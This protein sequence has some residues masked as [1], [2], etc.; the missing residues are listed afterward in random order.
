M[1]KR[2]KIILFIITFMMLLSSYGFA[3]GSTNYILN[4]D[5]VTKVPIPIS[6]SVTKVINYLGNDVSFDSPSDLFIDA[7]DNIYVADTGNNRI[8]KLNPDGSF[9]KIYDNG[10]TLNQPSGIFV[11]DTGDLYIAD[12]GNQQIVHLSEN[13][14]FVEKFVKPTSD[15][16]SATMDFSV[17][18]LAV[19]NQGYIYVI[20]DQQFMTIDAKD[21]FK[22]FIG[23]NQIGFDLTRLLIRMFATADQKKKLAQVQ[24]PVYTNF[25]IANDGMIYAVAPTTSGQ[26]KVINPI[27]QNIYP[28]KFYGEYFTT[29]SRFDKYPNFVDI[30]VDNDGII[31]ALE[32]KTKQLYQYDQEGNLLSVF[33]GD[34]TIQGKFMEP[35]SL[36]INSKGELFVL[37]AGA[38]TIQVFTPTKFISLVTNAVNLYNKGDYANALNIWQHVLKIDTNYPIANKGIAKS[39]YKEGKIED[40]MKYYKIAGDKAGYGMVYNEYKY[41]LFREY[42]AY[43]IIITVLVVGGFSFI[44]MKLKKRADDLVKEYFS[45][46]G[47]K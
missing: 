3:L 13:G 14:D 47:K 19:S 45:H 18:S 25:K 6:Y 24:P 43:V 34:G 31:T 22:G 1:K 36:D 21:Q 17:K 33:G 46:G 20:K 29:D 38:N 9:N 37:D 12:T 15:L 27:G 28:D 41:Y 44:I 10:G 35:V 32:Q 26:I 30:T 4:D 40:S 11:D 8:I 23:A 39:L 42:F 5:G 7:K 16:L 2:T